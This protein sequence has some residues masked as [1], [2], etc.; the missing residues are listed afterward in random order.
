M[1]REYS[2]PSIRVIS[3]GAICL[4]DASS[5]TGTSTN[6]VPEGGTGSMSVVSSTIDK[7]ENDEGFDAVDSW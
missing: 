4:L 2:N 7:G 1:K 6:Q 5:S 3:I